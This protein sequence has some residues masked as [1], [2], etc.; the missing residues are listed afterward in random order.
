MH[1]VLMKI[2]TQNCMDQLQQKKFNKKIGK[3]CLLMEVATL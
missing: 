2:G 3:M 1:W